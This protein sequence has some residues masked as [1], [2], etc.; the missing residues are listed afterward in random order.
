MDETLDIPESQRSAM[1]LERMDREQYEVP[2]SVVLSSECMDMVKRLLKSDP[3]QRIS[4][5]AVLCHPW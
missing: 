3:A 5:E 2:S 4:L 1:M